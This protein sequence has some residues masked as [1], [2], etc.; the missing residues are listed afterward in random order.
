M[1]TIDHDKL[2]VVLF[3]NSDDL[4]S[5][6]FKED[7]GSDPLYVDEFI[8]HRATI[9]RENN[10]SVIYV[11]KYCKEIVGFFTLSMGALEVKKLRESDKMEAAPQL[12]QYPALLL[13]NMGVE[14]KF[15]CRGIG[16][17]ICQFCIGLAIENSTKIACGYVFL[18]SDN[19]KRGF[20]EKLDFV[21]SG[22]E[23]KDGKIW[24]Y[25]RIFK[26]SFSRQAFDYVSTSENVIVKRIPA[27]QDRLHNSD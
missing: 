14:K 23:N 17:W 25:R 3:S 1:E 2:D 22:K 16:K 24:M 7:D 18:Q 12:T 15:R 4:S 11:V 19:K 8:H 20:Y 9:Y 5:C 26:R 21:S 27:N 10:L 13:G 6:D